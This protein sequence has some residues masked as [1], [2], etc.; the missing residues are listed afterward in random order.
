VSARP[1]AALA[2]HV[3]GVALASAVDGDLP[4]AELRRRA[5]QELLRQAAMAAGLLAAND[6]VPVD[7]VPSEAASNAIEALL[8]QQLAVPEPDE[9][10]CRRWHAA[11]P[12]RFAQG[13][14]VRVRHILF[15]VTDGVDITKLR[16]RAE[17][18]LVDLRSRSRAEIDKPVAAGDRFA[19]AAAQLSNCPSGEHGGEL[20][21]LEA[22]DCAPEFAR[23]LFG[24]PERGMLPRLVHTRFGLHVVEVVQRKAGHVPA[25]EAVQ[26]AVRAALQRQAF[27]TAL[28]QHLQR[29]AGAAQVEAVE[30]D[31]TD[32]PLLQ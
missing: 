4:A 32:S 25:Y 29:L 18:C 27:A 28:R 14:R 21:W 24:Q 8:A 5:H 6:P 31:A 12:A 17:A 20:G 13:E 19:V 23:A 11:N 1:R 10:T 30:L 26:A 7:G 15:A 3:N 16:A 9:A 22:D 2:P